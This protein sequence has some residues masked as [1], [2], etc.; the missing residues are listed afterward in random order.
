[1]ANK[2]RL[3]FFITAFAVLLLPWL[4]QV[5]LTPEGYVPT[6]HLLGYEDYLT[7]IAK[8]KWGEQGHWTYINRFT[9]EPTEPAPIYFFYLL[10]GH[11][12]RLTG[13]SLLWV[14]HLARS[15][16]GALCL[17]F[18]WEFC[19]KHVR[20]PVVA[21]LIG[22]FASFGYVK[23]G[24]SLF[25]HQMYVQ[26]HAAYTCLLGFTHY[27]IDF[28]AILA[29]F[30][31][32]LSMRHWLAVLAGIGLS[33]VHPFLLILFPVIILVHAL[34][35]RR[36]YL[37]DAITVALLAGVGAL[38][39]ALPMY[40]AYQKIEWLKIWREQTYYPMPWHLILFRL[41]L[42]F[43]LAGIIAWA[44]IPWVMRRDKALD[45][46]LR[47]RMVEKVSGIWM[48]LAALLVIFAPLPNR[49]E[50]GFFLSLPIGVLA[51]PWLVEFSERITTTK[52][53]YM[54]PVLVLLCTFYGMAVVPLLCV[55]DTT[56]YHS[57]Q[58]V[59]G[60]KWLEAN[61][62]P[63]DGV[64]C[65]WMSGIF[66]PVYIE[67]PRPW[68]AHVAE[69]INYDEK[70]EKVRQYF[71]RDGKA[72]IPLKWAVLVKQVDK[73]VPRLSWEPVYEN[74]EIVIWENKN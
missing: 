71:L 30:E 10:L 63:E 37:K 20:H 8:M 15:V 28:M 56:S 21:F 26:G 7:F 3:I 58:M 23:P 49:R 59:E 66:I 1:M 12:A 16:L 38:P 45:E 69:T 27:T 54:L 50:F 29:L 57:D 34:M 5:A 73:D 55:P 68:V 36:E 18:W 14:F 60:L 40:L 11:I 53:N 6:G 67:H 48:V 35:F 64:I 51:A 52:R 47:C 2:Q 41:V 62:N 32:Y 13:L 46:V 43:G 72:D 39:F 24:S 65:T 61:S 4:I 9:T 31:A 44:R 42:S 70:V 25:F 22:I 17:L 19:R 74:D 33:M